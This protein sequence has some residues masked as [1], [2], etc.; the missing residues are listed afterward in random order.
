MSAAVECH[1]VQGLV[2]MVVLGQYY[3]PTGHLRLPPQ[4]Y[5]CSHDLHLTY[6]RRELPHIR[7]PK[8]LPNNFRKKTFSPD[9]RPLLVNI[10]QSIYQERYTL[11]QDTSTTTS[12]TQSPCTNPATFIKSFAEFLNARFLPPIEMEHA[13]HSVTIQVVRLL[14]GPK[15]SPIPLVSE[16]QGHS[17]SSLL[18]GEPDVH[19]QLVPRHK[20]AVSQTPSILTDSPN[21]T[22]QKP[23]P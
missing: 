9:H 10:S 2:H 13:L 7:Y 23:L 14:A 3:R 19:Q 12:T 1:Y 4:Y 16:L 17:L 8:P 6:L 21:R 22:H 20:Q 15:T 5:S 18:G 11:A